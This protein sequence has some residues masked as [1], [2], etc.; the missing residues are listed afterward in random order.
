MTILCK[1]DGARAVA[2]QTR[3]RPPRSARS[4]ARVWSQSITMLMRVYSRLGSYDICQKA[5][6]G[7][8]AWQSRVMSAKTAKGPDALRATITENVN[9]LL[10]W[11]GW[12][13]TEA[14]RQ[15]ALRLGTA[16][17]I[18]QSQ[19]DRL[20]KGSHAPNADTLSRLA[21]TFGVP[22]YCL[23][24]PDLNPADAPELLTR[25]KLDALVA[26]AIE[27]KWEEVGQAL[28]AP[29]RAR[30]EDGQERSSVADPYAHI[31]PAGTGA[32]GGPET[33]RKPAKSAAASHRDAH[34]RKT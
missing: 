5:Y 26:E 29:L 22:A 6:L 10:L 14:A 2:R 27:E 31:P 33:H 12:T 24:V 11:K 19:F 32:K 20:V 3:A 15:S 7:C 9:A 17:M 23:L 25:K 28:K 21:R 4:R 16:G 13:P 18:R 30:D 34:H 1:C 8:D